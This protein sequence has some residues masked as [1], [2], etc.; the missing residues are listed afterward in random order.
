METCQVLLRLCLPPTGG[1]MRLEKL[2]GS[3]AA[4]LPV[5]WPAPMVEQFLPSLC[6]NAAATWHA[7]GEV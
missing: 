4:R 3:L 7:R 1:L 5:A 2:R 6:S